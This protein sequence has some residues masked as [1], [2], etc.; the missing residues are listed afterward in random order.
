MAGILSI[1]RNLSIR[2]KLALGFGVMLLVLIGI[3]IAINVLDT[4]VQT[5]IDSA[6]DARREARLAEELE[7][8]M[9]LADNHATIYAYS[10]LADNPE[11]TQQNHDQVRCCPD[12]TTWNA[13]L[14]IAIEGC[15]WTWDRCVGPPR[16][17]R[18]E[19]QPEIDSTAYAN[20]N[21]IRGSFGSERA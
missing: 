8:A 6:E 21:Q 14:A 13:K 17:K 12:S 19:K 9:M 5:T 16:R 20:V 7:T 18:L 4:N 1:F 15:T 3:Q 2:W 11:F 10:L